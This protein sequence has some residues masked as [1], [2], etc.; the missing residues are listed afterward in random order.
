MRSALL[1]AL[2]VAGCSA[3]QQQ[4]TAALCQKDAALQPVA[5]SIA[6]IVAPSSGSVVAVDQAVVHPAIVAACAGISA[7]PVGATVTTPS[8]TA[9]VTVPST[10]TP[11]KPTS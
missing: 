9:N 1:L 8:G 11:A 5:V 7:V 2:L 10:A 4:M 3:S 6:P